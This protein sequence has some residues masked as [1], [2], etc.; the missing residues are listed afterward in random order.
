MRRRPPISTRTDTLFPYTTLFRAPPL[1]GSGRAWNLDASR[2]AD[3]PHPNPSP[4]GEGHFGAVA[5]R[6]VGVMA[7]VAGWRPDELWAATPAA[8]EA[9]LAASIGRAACR[10]RGG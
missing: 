2:K 7:Q 5:L 4:E 10:D 3:G 1:Q 6:L 8:V 9:V